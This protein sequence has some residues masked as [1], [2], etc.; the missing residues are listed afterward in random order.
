MNQYQDSPFDQYKGSTVS[1]FLEP[2][3]N[4][5]YKTYQQVITLSAVPEGPLKEMV[6]TISSVKLS[7][8]QFLPITSI[9]I[10][11]IPITSNNPSNCIHVL[12]RYKTHNQQKHSN[13][14]MGRDDIPSIFAYLRAIGYMVDTEITK[15]MNKSGLMNGQTEQRLSGERQLICIIT[16]SV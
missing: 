16:C 3:L 9:P 6:S 5:Y 11:S 15:L 8:F 1:L 13:Y 10:T 4:T 14:Y 7:P 12:C 2:I